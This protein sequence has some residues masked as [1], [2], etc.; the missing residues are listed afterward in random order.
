MSPDPEELRSI[1]QKTLDATLTEAQLSR[2]VQIARV[3]CEA[4][5]QHMRPAAV[6]LAAD[7]GNTLTELAYDCLGELFA[8]DAELRFPVIESFVRALNAPLAS[9]PGCDLVVA[10]RGLVVRVTDM[11]LARF[12]ALADPVGRK[13][14]RNIRSAII[15]GNSRLI[16]VKDFR[17]SVLQPAQ[18][19]PLDEREAFPFELLQH[20]FLD[21]ARH[22]HTIP[23]LLDI[24]HAIVTEQTTY[25]RSLPFADVVQ[26]C[27][28]VYIEQEEIPAVDGEPASEGFSDAEILQILT[29]VE[30]TL[31]EKILVTYLATGKLNGR[32]AEGV[33]LAL[34]DMMRDWAFTGSAASLFE[35]VHRHLGVSEEEYY[36]TLRTK[37]EYLYRLAREEFAARLTKEL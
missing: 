7:Q 32:Q 23:E 22:H 29:Q 16:L 3:M 4:H 27:K 14:K 20:H 2:F 17:G 26:L 25:R 18:C 11:H 13:I 15:Q 21:C 30:R 36:E 9:I 31:Q 6:K 8:R 12:F 24:I 34:R 5:L 33:F 10:L 35:H 19:D 1:V 37:V 28:L